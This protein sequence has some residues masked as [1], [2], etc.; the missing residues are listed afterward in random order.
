MFFR[1]TQSNMYPLA[2]VLRVAWVG[3]GSNKEGRYEVSLRDGSTCQVSSHEVSQFTQAAWRFVAASPGTTLLEW[4][5]PK[6]QSNDPFHRSTVFVWGI[7]HEGALQPMAAD[8]VNEARN[9]AVVASDG[10]VSDVLGGSF[11]D[12]NAYLTHLQS[13]DQD[14]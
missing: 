11:P 3:S 5:G 8:G 7:D 4:K 6:A 1:D 10:T 9:W 12:E 2:E 13:D 14:S